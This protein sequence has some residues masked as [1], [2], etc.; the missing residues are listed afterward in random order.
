MCI[1]RQDRRDSH[2]CKLLIQLSTPLQS[3]CDHCVEC[4]QSAQFVSLYL[5]LV[6]C[7]TSLQIKCSSYYLPCIVAAV[8]AL[9]IINREE[10]AKW[11]TVLLFCF[12]ISNTSLTSCLEIPA[13]DR[14][15]II[16][17]YHYYHILSLLSHI[18]TIIT[19]Y[20]Y[21][22]MLSLLSHI[23]TYYHYQYITAQQYCNTHFPVEYWADNVWLQITD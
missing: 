3:T 18:I 14:S 16:I 2:I 15:I 11:I 8:S 13:Q 5:F 21:Y 22:H 10:K 17:Y 20:H 7:Y 23:K 4:K 19:Y 6:L 9:H 12:C 1:F